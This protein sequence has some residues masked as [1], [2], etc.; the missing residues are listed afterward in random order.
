M[1]TSNR[2]TYLVAGCAV[3]I[4]IA[5]GCNSPA[6]MAVHLVGKAVDTGE[7]KKLG[8]ELIGRP[9]AAADAKFGQP[10]EVLTQV[11]GGQ[12][13]RIYPVKL[14]VL[15][16][17]R[18][19]VEVSGNAVVGIFKAKRDAT[20]IDLARKTL[21]DEKTKGKS[22]AECGTALGMGA[23]LLTVRS[24]TNGT[25]SQLYDARTIKIGSPKYCR[26]RFD[27]S[28]RCD[29]VQIIDVNASAGEKPPV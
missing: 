26:L 29:E 6:G 12:K 2:N 27:A 9:P 19:V 1:V 20:G 4:L 23:P 18:Y 3:A 17:Q 15:D 7:T 16:N 28:Q 11:G 8:D 10:I 14:D 13:W 21:L 5:A 25:T 22:P 24:E